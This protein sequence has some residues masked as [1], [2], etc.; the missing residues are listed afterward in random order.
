MTMG[1]LKSVDNVPGIDFYEYRDQLYWNKYTYRARFELKGARYTWYSD[2]KDDL[3]E[4]LNNKYT[5]FSLSGQERDKVM[6]NIDLLVKFI[7][8]RNL[9]KKTKKA[10]IRIE[11]ETVAVFSNDLSLLQTLQ[12]ID[13]SIELNYTECQ[14]T[15]F[16]G[17]KHFVETPKHNYRI[18]LKSKRIVGTF[19]D[20]LKHTLATS[21]SLYPSNALTAWLNNS[22]TRSWR[23]C[24]TSASHSIDYDEES[25]LSYLM[26]MYGEMFGK[27]YKLEKRPDTI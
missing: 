26:L 10:S 15:I 8:W 3:L 9:N 14:T 17:T 27:R 6:K 23:Y 11:G 21:K 13:T 24:Y 16:A 2:D 4:R 1:L 5:V 12:D 22:N 25:T 20:D 18:Y 7:E 19:V